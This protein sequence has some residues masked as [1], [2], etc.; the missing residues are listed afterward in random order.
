V[1]HQDEAGVLAPGRLADI[2]VLDRDPFAVDPREL[3][4]IR[5][6]RTYVGGAQ[7]HVAD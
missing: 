1:N 3:H 4:G 5:C 2:A 6:V 7:V